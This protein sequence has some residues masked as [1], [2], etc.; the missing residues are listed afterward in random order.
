M[1]C[2]Y[3]CPTEPLPRQ[4]LPGTLRPPLG[5]LYAGRCRCRKDES[6]SPADEQIE[7]GCNFGYA[8]TKCVRF[9]AGEGPDAV[10][11]ILAEDDGR[12]VRIRYAIERDHLPFGHGLAVFQR[13]RAEWKGVEGLLQTQ[14]EA[15][16]KS[17]LRWKGVENQ[18]EENRSGHD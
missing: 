3:F 5:E 4:P 7:E 11:F 8:R 10:R 6:V 1:A 17:Y 15:Y 12:E 14:A 16:L 9:P 13:G 2:P 18:G